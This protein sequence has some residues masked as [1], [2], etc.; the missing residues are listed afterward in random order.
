MLH[1]L[2]QMTVHNFP[3]SAFK[4]DPVQTQ[5]AINIWQNVTERPG[6]TK[7][8]KDG[9]WASVG[10]HYP[11]VSSYHSFAR[12]ITVVMSARIKVWWWNAPFN[13]LDVIEPEFWNPFQIFLSVLIQFDE[14]CRLFL[15]MFCENQYCILF[16]RID[17]LD[18]CTMKK[19]TTRNQCQSCRIFVQY[20][21]EPKSFDRGNGDK[22]LSPI[23]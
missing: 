16:L 11:P 6:Q 13:R 4:T 8:D 17:P 3:R 5:I 18:S 1:G 2:Q 19:S 12:S 10:F 20:G 21:P 9:I 22:N 14:W 23:I 15:W 7:A